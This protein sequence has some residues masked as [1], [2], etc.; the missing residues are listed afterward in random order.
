ML[1][2]NPCSFHSCDA[3]YDW[4][5]AHLP[6]LTFSH[7]L[8]SL[9]SFPGFAPFLKPVMLLEVAGPLPLQFL[10]P[11]TLCPWVITCPPLSHH[12]DLSSNATSLE[13]GPK[14]HPCRKHSPGQ[15]FANCTLFT[16]HVLLCLVYGWSLLPP[17]PNTLLCPL[18]CELYGGRVLVCLA[19]PGVG[20][21]H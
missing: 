16:A 19:H 1:E 9:C 20:Q 13:A 12:T 2:E 3:L 14:V 18:G 4:V 11:G 5:P 17:S 8:S 10:L 7:S 21:G 15:R 6:N